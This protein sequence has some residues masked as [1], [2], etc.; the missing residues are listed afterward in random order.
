MTGL[1]SS[2]SSW[3]TCVYPPEAEGR[4]KR[5]KRD[6]RTHFKAESPAYRRGEE[7]SSQRRPQHPRGFYS[8]GQT[9]QCGSSKNGDSRDPPPPPTPARTWS[10]FLQHSTWLF[11]AARC[12]GLKPAG[13]PKEESQTFSEKRVG[14]SRRTPGYLRR[15]WWTGRRCGRG[16]PRD[17]RRDLELLPRED[18]T[19]ETEISA[20]TTQ[21]K[22]A[23]YCLSLQT[24]ATTVR[25]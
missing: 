24:P 11:L 4:L 6:R 12:K 7:P 16:E 14:V 23:S 2:H 20:P 21:P 19:H 15:R 5:S 1:L 8:E 9:G 10:S 18:C 17:S 13:E 25:R 22:T 3:T